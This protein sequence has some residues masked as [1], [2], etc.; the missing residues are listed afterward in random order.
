[1]NNN[2]EI[3]AIVPARGGSTG[4][5]RKNLRDIG[6]IPLVART[7]M[8]A[9]EANIFSRIIVASD[10]E[11]INEVSRGYGAETPFARPK[12]I[13]GS[14]SHMFLVYSHILESL[15]IV[16]QY[17]PKGFCALL[18]TTPF[19]TVDAIRKSAMM[20]ASGDYDWVLSINECEHH[21]YRA[22]ELNNKGYITP[23]FNIDCKTM[24][25][26][27]QELPTL[28]RFNGGII[29]G[30]S[31]HVYGQNEYNI[32]KSADLKVGQVMLSQLE[33]FDIDTE[34]DME[35]AQYLANKA[36]AK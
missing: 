1:M 19:R 33:S 15:K 32:S 22:M 25:S 27:R 31:K 28:Y 9:Q 21:P 2:N 35:Y 14:T 30:L 29:G 13:S 8:Q 23:F 26:N 11:E 34:L 18:P 36:T 3:I 7:I 17:Q 5:I 24:W 6:G 12:E 16:E 10:S 20:L 4:V